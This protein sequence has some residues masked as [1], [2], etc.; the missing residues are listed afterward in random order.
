M[1][2]KSGFNGFPGECVNFFKDLGKNNNREWF[3][4]HKGEM[5][6]YVLEPARDFV[7]E[8]GKR[9]QK[10]SPKIIADPRVNKSI[11]RMYRDTRFSKDKTPYKTHLGILFWEGDRAKLECPGFY[12]HAEPP[13]LMLGAGVYRFSKPL[14]TVYR[15][16]VVDPKHGPALVKALK[17]VEKKGDCT[18]GGKHYKRTPRGYDPE[19]KNAEL[20]LYNGLTAG[21]T[22]KLPKEFHSKAIVDYCFKRFKEMSPINEWLLDMIK[23]G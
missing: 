19:H 2:A 12:F 6:E 3:A 8:M 13:D 10:I 15:D 4:K 16:S 22:T 23:R 9:L 17:A 20:L 5:E 11:F 1:A 18:I 14:M 21:V 7:F